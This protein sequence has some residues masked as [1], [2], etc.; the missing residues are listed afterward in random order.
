MG[1]LLIERFGYS[2]IFIKLLKQGDPMSNAT[3]LYCR[4]CKI[5]IP[6]SG[7]VTYSLPKSAIWEDFSML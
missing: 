4:K 6:K 3:G 7:F 1:L 5:I 2:H